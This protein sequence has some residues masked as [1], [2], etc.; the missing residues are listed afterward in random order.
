MLERIM[1]VLAIVLDRYR[2]SQVAELDYDLRI[3]FINFDWSNI[4]DD[5]FDLVQHVSDQDGVI[6]RKKSPRLL[7]DRW[8]RNI[9]VITVLFD[10]VD[11]VVGKFLRAVIRRRVESCLRAIIIDR[12]TA[13]DI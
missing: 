10:G 1:V 6:S 7:N 4:L 5:R 3:V 8:M 12:H 9:L 2:L 13:A 11:D